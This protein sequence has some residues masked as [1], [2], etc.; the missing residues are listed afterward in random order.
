MTDFVR[1]RT[2][3]ARKTHTCSL[4]D[5]LI[6]PGEQYTRTTS[7]YDGRI[8]DFLVCNGCRED[9]VLFRVY[10]WSVDA[11]EGV[12]LDDAIE[13]ANEHVEH[14]TDDSKIAA[15]NYLDRYRTSKGDDQ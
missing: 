13:W 6:V 2:P 12:T 4:C 10:A 11:Y 8:A 15:R 3:T 1:E 14:G 9:K 7:V 5:G